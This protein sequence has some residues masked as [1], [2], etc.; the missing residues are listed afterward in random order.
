[1]DSFLRC[2]FAEV[3][4]AFY[5][6][7]KPA[8]MTV[9]KNEGQWDNSNVMFREGELVRYDKRNPD[10]EMRHIDYGLSVVQSAVFSAYVA[11]ERFDLADIFTKLS[12]QRQLA[13]HE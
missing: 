4:A 8:L 3:Q 2:S 11:N 1:G 6:A 10:S 5:R 7:G 9:L 13:G 12:A